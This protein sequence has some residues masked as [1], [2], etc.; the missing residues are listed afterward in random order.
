MARCMASREAVIE[1]MEDRG[2]SG[3]PVCGAPPE[4]HESEVEWEYP[5]VR[6]D[7]PERAVV[8]YERTIPE[9]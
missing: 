1:F 8:T 2:D 7:R 5:E 4:E 3:C 9:Q 6:P